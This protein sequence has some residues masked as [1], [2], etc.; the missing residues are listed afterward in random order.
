VEI[1]A[2]DDRSTDGSLEWLS[3][4]A[5]EGRLRVLAG[6]GRGLSAA[7]NLGV[8]ASRYPVICQVDQDVELLPGWVDRLT[9]ELRRDSRL[10]R[11]AGPLHALS[12][13]PP[14]CAR[15]EP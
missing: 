3:T 12:R 5:A 11:G 7:L 14:S 9:G 1:L 6:N 8:R 10:G 13:G 2:I 4:R 15:D